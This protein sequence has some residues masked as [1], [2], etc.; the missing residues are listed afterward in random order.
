MKLTGRIVFNS[1]SF[2]ALYPLPE[3]L[4]FI[5]VFNVCLP[6]LQYVAV[7]DS[8]LFILC[9]FTFLSKKRFNSCDQ[10]I[11]DNYSNQYNF[12]RIKMGKK[13]IIGRII[14]SLSK[15]EA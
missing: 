8:C 1:G 2:I 7:T 4:K 13:H 5:T 3:N 9:H 15:I 6:V 11:L 12:N 14:R 10:A